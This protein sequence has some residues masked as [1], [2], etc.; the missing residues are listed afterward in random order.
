MKIIIVIVLSFISGFV[1]SKTDEEYKQEII[2]LYKKQLQDNPAYM[3]Q[4][5]D[6][7][8][9]KEIEEL[10]KYAVLAKQGDVKAMFQ[11]SEKIRLIGIKNKDEKLI[12]SAWFWLNES[13]EGGYSEALKNLGYVYNY[14]NN[15]FGI[16]MD[17]Q[18]AANYYKLAAQKGDKDADFLYRNVMECE[19]AEVKADDC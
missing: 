12:K 5:R 1:L 19:I 3:K 7:Y 9:K 18:K 13:A 15:A 8:E 6:E 10:E 2:D 11:F 16:G 14:G 4:M 17:L